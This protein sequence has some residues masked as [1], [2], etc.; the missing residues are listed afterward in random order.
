MSYQPNEIELLCVLFLTIV[1]V[2][3][4]I[5]AGAVIGLIGYQ[6]IPYIFNL[7]EQIFNFLQL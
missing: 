4:A 6:V 5:I 7:F 2:I 1:G 3:I